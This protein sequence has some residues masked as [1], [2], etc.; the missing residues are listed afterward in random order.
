M[1]LSRRT[2]LASA[3]ALAAPWFV[4]RS[5]LGHARRAAASDRITL[6]LIGVRKMGG[7]HLASLVGFPDV[8]IVA[9]C[10]VDTATRESARRR[11]NAAYAAQTTAGAPFRGCE[12]YNEYEQV[13]A[14]PDVDA[15]VIAVPDHWHAKIAIEAARAGKDIYC[16]K[17]LALTIRDARRIVQAVRACGRVL[18]TGSQQRSEPNFRFACELVRNG[19][20]GDVQ[21][22]HVECGPPSRD[23]YLPEQPV[24]AGLDYDRWLGP[25]PHAPFHAERVGSFYWDGWRRWRDYSGGKM[26]DWGAHHF[27][28][29]QWGL[30]MDDAGPL[31]IIPPPTAGRLSTPGAYATLPVDGAGGAPDDPSRGLTY[32]YPGGIEVVKDGANGVRFVGSAG[33]VEV[34]RGYLATSPASLKS[35]EI[36]PNEL[37]LPRSPGHYENWLDCIRT[38]RRP[39]ADVEIG[40]RSVSVCHLG[41]IACWL[42]RPLRWNARREEFVG[43]DGASRLLDRPKRAGYAISG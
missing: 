15:V 8:Q 5:V 30:G 23:A 37:H 39:I 6:A 10:D 4:P 18:Q 25:A 16:E 42:N 26:T 13:L 34:N 12:A 17:P 24:P 27:D 29:A 3:A 9:V 1:K 2:M 38:R 41:N 40:C 36:G 20:I 7:A 32:R 22:V 11:V 31:E 43:D 35:I 19:Y 28:I 14:R 21:R 33:W